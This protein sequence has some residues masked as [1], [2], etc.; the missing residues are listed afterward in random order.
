MTNRREVTTTE[1]RYNWEGYTPLNF[2]ARTEFVDKITFK[3]GTKWNTSIT[4][5][6]ISDWRIIRLDIE[7]RQLYITPSQFFSCLKEASKNPQ[8]RYTFELKD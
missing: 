2:F 6:R 5:T 8:Y 7:H 3:V 1:D 4:Y